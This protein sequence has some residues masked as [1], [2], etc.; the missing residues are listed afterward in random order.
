MLDKKTLFVFPTSR[1]VKEYIFDF[2]SK[3][4]L[5]PTTLTIDEFLKKSISLNS[6]IY[7]Q[8]EQR[9][10]FLHEAIKSIDI[11]K[12]G[13]SNSFV[14]FL[15][16]G[17]YIYRFFLELSSEK[18]EISNLQRADT[19]E[20]YSEHLDILN[21]I[22]KNYLEI[23]EKNLY[24]DKVNLDK[25]YTINE[26]FIKRFDEITIVYEGYF[27]KQEYEIIKKISQKTKVF[28]KFYSNIYNK[29][30]IELFKDFNY[31]FKVD[32]EY[33]INLSSLEIIEEISS[34]KKLENFDIKGFST[35][36]NQVAYIKSTI[37]NLINKG[38]NPQNIAVILP[39]ENFAQ[40]LELNDNEE[41]FN[42]AMGRDIKN[43]KLYQ[44]ANSIFLYINSPEIET[45]EALKYFDIDKKYVD[46]NIKSIWNIHISKETF[47]NIC[48]FI[49]KDEENIE[50][51][52]KFD[53]LIYRLNII[54]FT[55]HNNLRLKD[56]YKIFL[57]KLDEIKLD[58]AHSGKI[59]VMGLLETRA[60]K[61]D[62]VII[63]DFNDSY[64]PKISIKDKFLSTKVKYL[65]N[66][67]TKN[68]RENLQRY[69]YKRLTD[70][71]KNLYISYV[72]SN[73]D[74]ISKFAYELF[75]NIKIS[76]NDEDYKDILYKSKKLEYIEENISKD[77]DL[78][79]QIWSASGLKTFLECKRRWYFKYILKLN[80][81][82]IS[83]LPKAF[84][85]GDI[86]HKVLEE[87][88]KYSQRDI[89]KV[90]ELFLKYKSDNPFLILDLEVY[91]QKLKEF[92]KLDKD[93]LKT[94]DIVEIEKKFSTTFN[95][96]RITGVI[97]R[98][99]KFEDGFELIDYKTSRTLKV[100]TINTYP[101]SYDFQ[102]EFYFLA[103]KDLYKSSNIKA[104]YFDLFEN[105][106]KEEVVLEQKL[107]LLKTIF[108]DLKEQ[109]KE[110]IDFCK[111][112]DKSICEYCTY[113]TICNRD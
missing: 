16:Q 31:D 100:D 98:V 52:E 106:L 57:Q 97:D 112:D 6:Y 50:L 109:S 82:T 59:T 84:E 68:D 108:D 29:K 19:Y 1:A 48:E 94:R 102:L 72:S 67:P 101:K 26:S 51:V 96:F 40:I 62:A 21:Q 42:F 66:L 64:I 89:N 38:I 79:K 27:T 85:L 43:K 83:R 24:V 91:K 25:F 113:K 3:N 110:T 92:L 39:N 41:Y 55:N 53:E 2:K 32:F 87:F 76:T 90:D 13:I 88:Y 35:R 5:L 71:S 105:S 103:I 95:D 10:I 75:T 4:T 69:Y 20:F 11:K 44:R 23:L 49:K 107:E 111:T 12:L 34:N 58:D 80:E 47:E 36:F 8:D 63:C 65:A 37:V 70:N 22:Y 45:M 54:F 56:A 73:E 7:A 17:E 60:I 81:H 99:D 46:E 77:I 61:F 74:E 104:F 93:R 9:V 28:I 78:T 86:V 33:L 14:K 15:K 18:I 30:S